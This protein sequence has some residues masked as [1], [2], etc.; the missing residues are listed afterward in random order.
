VRRESYFREDQR[1]PSKSQRFGWLVGLGVI[2]FIVFELKLHLFA[3]FF[4]APVLLLLLL[5][6]V[7]VLTL[8]QRLSVRIGMELEWE[9]DAPSSRRFWQRAT[10]VVPL[11]PS[12]P[13]AEQVAMIHIRHSRKSPISALSPGRRGNRLGRRDQRIPLS[14]VESWSATYLSL[15]AVLRGG[16]A[17]FPVGMQR[18]AVTLLLSDGRRLNVPTELQPAFLQALSMAKVD[19]VKQVRAATVIR[20]EL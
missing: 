6:L 12:S 15:L 4:A 2:L 16:D 3:P 18:D 20:E 10:R 8:Q 13:E 1:W 5:L 9:Q 14:E 11:A 17:V 19:S 7:T